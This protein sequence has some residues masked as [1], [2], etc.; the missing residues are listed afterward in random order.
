MSHEPPLKIVQLTPSGRGAIA[1]LL[2]AGPGATAAVQ[3]RFQAAGGRPLADLPI[4]R[5]GFGHF[6]CGSRRGE[7]VVV[8]RRSDQWVE[9]HCHGG[10]AAAAALEKTLVELGCRAVPWGDWTAEHEDPLRAAAQVALARARTRRTA[11]VLLDQYDGALRRAIDAVCRCLRRR[12]ATLAAEQL[13]ALLA[14]ADLGRHLVDPWR[15]VL[16]GRPNV[17]KSSLINALVGYQRAIVHPAP[18]TTRDV[19][20]ATTAVEGWPVELSDTAGL[21]PAGRGIERAGIDLAREKLAAADLV[22]LVFDS[23]RPWAP[24]DQRLLESRPNALVIHN[25]RD[26]PAF[27][28]PRRPA[29][30]W[31]SAST[32]EGIEELVQ[33][34]ARRLVPEPPHAG[35]AVPLDAAQVERL[36]S[37]ADAVHRG[38]PAEALNILGG[39]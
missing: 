32:G 18:G 39:M 34:I 22:I 7:E 6:H 29:G 25:K 16:A 38:D 11:T 3:S 15:V 37:A 33:A 14:R 1:T 12:E 35:A 30:L 13:D 9:L 10:R 2:V 26:L 17:G 24:A 5:L 23:T 27:A 36:R 19:V 8:R 31:T 20:S 21:R 4:D 28:D